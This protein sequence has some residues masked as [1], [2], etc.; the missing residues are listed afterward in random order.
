MNTKV[1]I[2]IYICD[3]TGTPKKIFG[4]PTALEVVSQGPR[5][6]GWTLIK[7]KKIDFFN[8]SSD[9]HVISVITKQHI[10]EVSKDT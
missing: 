10:K 8:F 3:P 9:T 1:N 5:F 4:A 7:E 2:Y 6:L